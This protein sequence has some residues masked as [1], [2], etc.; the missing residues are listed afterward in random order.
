MSRQLIAALV[1]IGLVLQG[2]TQVSA[3]ASPQSQTERHCD[4]HEMA[5]KDCPCCADEL[6][7][8]GACA[9]LCSVLAALPALSLTLPRPLNEESH[10]LVVRGAS[11]PAY[12]PLN[13]PPIS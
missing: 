12:T 3:I 6:A 5:G 13:P 1:L 10:G 11:G 9:T 7:A 8:S 4:G 2:V